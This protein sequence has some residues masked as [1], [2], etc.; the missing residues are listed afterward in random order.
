[1]YRLYDS[2]EHCLLAVQ[3]NRALL[4]IL[5]INFVFYIYKLIFAFFQDRQRHRIQSG[6]VGV[7][8]RR[9]NTFCWGERNSGPADTH[10]FALYSKTFVICPQFLEL[11]RGSI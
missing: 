1:M 7:T 10:V 11:R 8:Q 6:R 3:E 2:Q 4:D 9:R 5:K